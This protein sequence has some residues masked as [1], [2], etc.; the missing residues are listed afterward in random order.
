MI[1]PHHFTNFEMQRYYQN[2]NKFNSVNSRNKSSKIRD[3]AY[4]KHLDEFKSMETHW[5][6]LHVN[7]DNSIY[8]DSLEVAHIPKEIEHKSIIGNISGIQRYD[9]IM[10]EYFWIG[11]IDFVLKGKS[12]LD[13][14]IS[15]HEYGK[16]DKII[17]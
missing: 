10:C 15:S 2:K 11:F 14:T 8:F 13:Y 17:L 4:V 3:G 6:A 16:N 5:M 9:S 1:L 12:L 7:D